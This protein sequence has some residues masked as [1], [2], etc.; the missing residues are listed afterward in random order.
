M[1]SVTLFTFQYGVTPRDIPM[2]TQVGAIIEQDYNVRGT[3][4]MPRT[5][6]D[7]FLEEFPH[8]RNYLKNLPLKKVYVSRI[9]PAFLNYV[10]RLLNAAPFWSLRPSWQQEQIIFLDEDGN[11]LH[12]IKL[13]V[14]IGSSVECMEAELAER[15]VSI[16][17]YFSYTKTAI[18]YKTPKGYSV[19]GW[20][21]AQI[22]NE[23]LLFK[24]EVETIDQEGED[25]RQGKSLRPEPPKSRVF[26]EGEDPKIN[27]YSYPVEGPRRGN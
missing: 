18:L 13:G 7:A 26:K 25:V 10:P 19:P 15:I 8:V 20:I 27:E 3:E 9:E 21:K 1:E 4:E 14:S 17:S 23:R 5:K 12:E 22:M 6:I 16:L 24:K 11:A 2:K